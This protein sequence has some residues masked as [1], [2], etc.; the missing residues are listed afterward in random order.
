MLDR[1]YSEEPIPDPGGLLDLTGEELHHAARVNRARKGDVVEV[2]D[3]FGSTVEARFVE[4]SRVNARL[5]VVRRLESSREPAL[6]LTLCLALLP[7]E[8]FELVLQKGCELGVSRFLPLVSSR[9]EVHPD[10]ISSKLSRWH[11]II[12]ESIKQCGRSRI[13]ELAAPAGFDEIVRMPGARL[14]FDLESTTDALPRGTVETLSVFIGPEGGFD[15]REIDLAI[16]HGAQIVRLG[17]RRLRAETAAI[18]AVTWAGL[19]YGDL[20]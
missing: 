12:L 4:I 6:Q 20:G 13:P 10:R 14:V 18:A 11:R 1:Y 19:R 15:R 16:E 8:K 3:R 5:E 9:V 7:P 2:F 17:P